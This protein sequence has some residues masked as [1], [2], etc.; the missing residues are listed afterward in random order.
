MKGDEEGSG[1][2]GNSDLVMVVELG[3]VT[4]L[5]VLE[6]LMKVGK[7]ALVPRQTSLVSG[8][9][10]QRGLRKVKLRV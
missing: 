8:I 6:V 1:G 2:R 4:Q 10:F 5:P 9:V 7:I 3:V